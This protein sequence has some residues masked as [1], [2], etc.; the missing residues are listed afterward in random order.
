MERRIKVFTYIDSLDCFVT[1]KRFEMIS[2]YLGLC[3]WT[4]VVWM[5]RLFG[6]DNDYAEH[7]FDNF[8]EREEREEK[9]KRDGI[10]LE[11]LGITD[12][13]HML[14]VVPERFIDRQDGPCHSD[15]LRKTFWTDVFKSLEISIE[16]LVDAAI[17][18]NG[19][20]FKMR[21]IKDID[22]RVEF[23]RS[24]PINDIQREDWWN[25]LESIYTNWSPDAS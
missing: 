15:A 17:E 6:L 13:T 12:I 21:A 18:L 1:C 7:F 22:E 4:P 16:T 19:M 24:Y 2:C 14:I 23:V 20:R 5:C 10:D 25:N 9:A 3:E 8:E 11:S